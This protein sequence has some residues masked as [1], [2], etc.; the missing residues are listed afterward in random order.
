MEP[1]GAY[2]AHR[3]AALSGV[4]LSTVHDWARKNVLVPSVSPRRVQLWSY[5]DLMGLRTIAWLRHPKTAGD[6]SDVPATAMHAVRRALGRLRE[7]DLTLWSEDSG[8]NVMV[9]RSG[10]VVID[11]NPRLES[12][13]GQALLPDD[14]MLDLIA[15]FPR[16]DGAH[17]PDLVRPRPRL[18]I[19]PSRLGGA[20]HVED[21]RVDTESLGSLARSGL[22]A[23]AI[24][25]LYPSLDPAGID[26]ALDLE[27]Q[28]AAA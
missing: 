18:R 2:T 5:A 16:E 4:P 15:P 12:A 26:D 1:R 28:L 11:A 22:P 10:D 23:E 7:L 24:Y 21:S 14:D 20:P 19:V 17:G 6:G 27:R 8:P 9:T 13:T 25:A 3:A